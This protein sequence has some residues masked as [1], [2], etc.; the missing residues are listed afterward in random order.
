M[1]EFPAMVV[2]YPGTM[3][4]FQD[5]TYDW[6]NVADADELQAALD[7]GFHM[8]ADVA[9]EAHEAAEADKRIKAANAEKPE[10]NAPPTRA[11]LEAKAKELGIVVDGRMGDKKLA[12]QI[13]DK[14][15]A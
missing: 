15:K 9:R 5:G 4:K 14:L 13:A 11:E 6:R 2:K 10:D 3:E 8:G 12:A 7:E 1:L